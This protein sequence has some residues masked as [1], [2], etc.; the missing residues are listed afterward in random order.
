MAF[1]VGWVVFVGSLF[2]VRCGRGTGI[3]C[4]VFAAKEKS[5]YVWWKSVKKRSGAGTG[6]DGT[7]PANKRI[8]TVCYDFL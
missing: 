4:W 2:K 8:Y 6:R 1:G 7:V 5:N 3:L